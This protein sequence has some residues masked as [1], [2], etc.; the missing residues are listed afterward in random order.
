MNT[1]PFILYEA[2]FMVCIDQEVE[3]SVLIGSGGE[4]PEWGEE[5][6]EGNDDF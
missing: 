3:N 1:K 4:L 6:V 5:I 2:P